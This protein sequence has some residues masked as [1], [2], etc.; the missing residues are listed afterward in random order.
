MSTHPDTKTKDARKPGLVQPSGE[1]EAVWASNHETPGTVT[2]L[3]PTRLRL[4][5]LGEGFE[6]LDLIIGLF[7]RRQDRE[8]L[9]KGHPLNVFWD[10]FEEQARQYEA[11]KRAL[12]STILDRRG[13]E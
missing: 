13:R 5:G 9:D 6:S 10:I 12:A 1:P 3:R 7:A 2:G 4:L 11:T 8:Q